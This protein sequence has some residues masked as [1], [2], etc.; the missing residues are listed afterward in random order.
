TALGSFLLVLVAGFSPQAAT[1]ITLVNT[2]FS[3][4]QHSNTRTPAWSGYIVQRPEAHV[5][6]H[7]R[8]SHAYNDG[9]ITIYDMLFGPWKTPRNFDD[10][11]GFYMAASSRISDMLLFKDVYKEEV[12]SSNGNVVS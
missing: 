6:H 3:M 5:L 9:D 7:A 1:V 12:S 8:G 2:F 11:S 10:E 4:F